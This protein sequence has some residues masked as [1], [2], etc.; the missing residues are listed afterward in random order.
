[1][2]KVG[3]QL[4][5]ISPPG[6]EFCIH[7]PEQYLAEHTHSPQNILFLFLSKFI[8]SEIDEM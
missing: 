7:C 1:M 3:M 4:C 5:Q 2:R 8:R 6:E